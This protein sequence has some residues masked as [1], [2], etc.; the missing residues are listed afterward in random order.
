MKFCAKF[1]TVSVSR[2]APVT[3]PFTFFIGDVRS[4]REDRAL[5]FLG[6]IR[7]QLDFSSKSVKE[8]LVELCVGAKLVNFEFPRHPDERSVHIVYAEARCMTK[9]SEPL[10]KGLYSSA[11]FICVT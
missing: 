11:G 8:I 7:A 9:Q 10:N 3:P 4:C 5:N 2:N 6:L 1:F